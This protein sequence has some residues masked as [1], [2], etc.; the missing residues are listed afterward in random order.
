[1]I[2]PVKVNYPSLVKK[3]AH[4]TGT[5]DT[6]DLVMLFMCLGEPMSVIAWKIGFIDANTIG[7]VALE[8]VLHLSHLHFRC[9]CHSFRHGSH[10]PMVLFVEILR[11]TCEH[12]MQHPAKIED[13]SSNIDCPSLSQYRPK[14]DKDNLQKK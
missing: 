3:M 6:K 13:W 4:T 8:V 2:S 5:Y 12:R 7:C 9:Y 10:V 14:A 1:M 11:D